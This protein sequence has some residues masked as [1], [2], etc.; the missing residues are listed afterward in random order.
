MAGVV[1]VA[2]LS[3]SFSFTGSIITS[4]VMVIPVISECICYKGVNGVL[5]IGF[6]TGCVT[7]VLMLQAC[8]TYHIGMYVLQGCCW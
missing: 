6:L 4:P 1:V 3:L 7:R 2:S 8:G 5:L